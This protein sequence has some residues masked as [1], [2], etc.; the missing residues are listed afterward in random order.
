MKKND[1]K[2]FMLIEIIA[3][4]VIMSM[5]LIVVLPLI[6]NA[7]TTARLKYFQDQENMMLISGKDYFTDNREKLP[8]NQGD[9]EVVILK[10][11]VDN[12]YIKPIKDAKKDIC[13]VNQSY[14]EVTNLSSGN[15]NYNIRLVCNDYDTNINWSEWSDWTTIPPVG[16]QTEIQKAELYNY[17]ELIEYYSDWSNWQDIAYKDDN[18]IP[19][20]S[21]PQTEIQ[22]RMI[23][24]YK[25]QQWKWYYEAVETSSCLANAPT[26]TGWNKDEVCG[27]TSVQGCKV[28][29]DGSSCG[30]EEGTPYCSASGTGAEC[31]WGDGTTCSTS[32]TGSVCGS[33]TVDDTSSCS[34]SGT[35]SICGTQTLTTCAL[36]STSPGAGWSWTP[37]FCEATDYTCWMHCPIKC[38]DTFYCATRCNEGDI[39]F[40]F[41]GSCPTPQ[42]YCGHR[43]CNED[44]GYWCEV[45]SP[46]KPGADWY[47]MHDPCN[48]KWIW[49]KVVDKK[50]ATKNLTKKYNKVVTG[51]MYTPTTTKYYYNTKIDSKWYFNKV[52]KTYADNYYSTAPTGYPNI[53]IID[54]RYI[55]SSNWD[56]AKWEPIITTKPTE[57]TYRTIET[58]LQTRTRRVLT[59]EW[60]GNQLEQHI[61]LD[62]FLQAVNDKRLEGAKPTFVTIDEMRN[63]LNIKIDTKTFYR[64]RTRIY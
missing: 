31:S 51:R 29:G 16:Q 59:S 49:K 15:Y 6:A 35:G 42:T 55:Y 57:Y 36:S 44:C 64:Y 3:V 8:K 45:C 25:D 41:S 10:T 60:S 62:D 14:V 38:T 17:Q 39:D 43:V 63:D 54:T 26:G 9:S 27:Y 33:V 1:I 13:D 61:S 7:I 48:D 46:N 47:S 18:I 4:I 5:L 30:Y 34:T 20:N 21:T 11:L 52:I 2:A 58:K 12:S 37:T 56:N 24:R 40:G 19:I 28:G 32:G 23:Y 50:Y 53:D 22:E